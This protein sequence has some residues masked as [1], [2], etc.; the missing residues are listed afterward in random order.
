[1][2]KYGIQGLLAFAKDNAPMIIFI[3]EIDLLGLQRVGDNK[4]LHDFLTALQNTQTDDP[5]K[6]V[7]VMAATNSPETLDKALRQYGRLGKEIRF[8]YPGFKYRKQFLMK[9]LESM[10][11]NPHSFDIDTIVAKT[12]G[13]SYEDLKAIVRTAMTRAWAQGI[14][15]T[16]Q[17]IEESINTEINKIIMHD[18]KDLPESERRILATHFAGKALAMSLLDT[19]AKLDTVTIKAVMTEIQEVTAWHAFG[20]RDKKDVQQK[21]V[22]GALFTKI[23]H[24]TIELKTE[25]HVLNDVKVLIAGFIAEEILLG[26][27]GMQCHSE[28]NNK[29]YSIIDQLVFKGIDPNQL[30]KKVRE[31]L[32]DKAYAM[33]TQCR[34]EIRQLLEDHKDTL[35]AVAEE[36]MKDSIMSGKDVQTVIDSIKTK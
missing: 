21:I 33:L 27:C 31:Q 2:A 12:D 16:Q 6:I 22:H 24:D 32:R 5:S 25:M 19:H 7:I 30:S 10:A 36:L 9:E 35:A 23:L 26:S 13:K 28:D 34:Q 4:L 11:L 20:Q 8:E 17:L 18:R 29:A 3:D 14:P 15:L 1:I